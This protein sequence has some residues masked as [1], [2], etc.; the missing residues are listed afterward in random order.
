MNFDFRQGVSSGPSSDLGRELPNNAASNE[1]A[2]NLRRVN[3]ESEFLKLGNLYL[4]GSHTGEAAAVFKR[5]IQSFPESVQGHLNL[6]LLAETKGNWPE[7][8]KHWES[9]FDCRKD[10]IPDW[11]KV[12]KAKALLE[13][14]RLGL[15]QRIY[16][17]F[18]TKRPDKDWGLLGLAEIYEKR[19]LAEKEEAVLKKAIR[20]FPDNL[21]IKFRYAI[22]LRRLERFKVSDEQLSS[23]LGTQVNQ[24]EVLAN[25]AWNA[26]LDREYQL[27]ANRFKVLSD[28]YPYDLNYKRIYVLCLIDLMNFDQA[29]KC[30]DE[31]LH[32]SKNISDRL[33]QVGLFKGQYKL[34][35]ANQEILKLQTEFPDEPKVLLEKVSLAVLQY[36]RSANAEVVREVLNELESFCIKNHDELLFVGQRT[37]LNLILNQT[38]EAEKLTGLLDEETGVKTLE[39]IRAW[40]THHGGD[41]EKAKAIWDDIILNFDVAQVKEPD[42]GVLNRVDSNSMAQIADDSVL[43][44]TAIRNERW[45]LPWFLKYYRSIGCSKFFIIDNDSNDGSLE[46][47]N[48][49]DDVYVFWTEQSYAKSRSG[50]QWINSLV[51]KYGDN[52]WCLYVDVDEAL[53]IPEIEQTGIRKLTEYMS[54]KGQEAMFAFMLDMCSLDFE[55][56][57]TGPDYTDFFQDY[58]YFVN[59]Y[60]F[61]NI[62]ICPY[63]FTVGGVRKLI[64]RNENQTK[65]PIIRGGRNIKFLSSSHLI[66]PANLSDV[67]GVLLHFKFAGDFKSNLESDLKNNTRIPHC[68]MRHRSYLENLNSLEPGFLRANESLERYKSSE[69]LVRLGVIQ[70]TADF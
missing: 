16:S 29:Q 28:N 55:S 51:K 9:C 33:V 13:C 42:L 45:R 50:M 31:Y 35:E 11:W 64:G 22:F 10:E 66:T 26:R 7:A 41:L 58:N 60:H 70:K 15:A 40:S 6:A 46:Y 43:V 39:E 59:D 23:L 3:S 2:L 61:T 54:K 4:Q 48:S 1:S 53:I 20:K 12:K 69:Q 30:Y 19:G 47:L 57:V 27:A 65:T 8:L 52:K 18:A 34:F 49:Q 67:S 5:L 21:S 36:K 44:F 68:N 56:K 32:A 25:L 38:D 24:K 37:R 14:G 17:G 62:P 63:K